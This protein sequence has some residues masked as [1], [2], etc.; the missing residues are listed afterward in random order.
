MS[1][2]RQNNT[3]R[4]YSKT[5]TDVWQLNVKTILVAST[6]RLSQT[7]DN[8]TS[9]QYLSPV[10]KDYHRRM[11]I[12]RQ[13]NTCRQY[14]KTFTDVCQ[15]NVNTIL[16]ASTQRLSHTYINWTSRQYLSPVLKDYQRHMSIKRQ[17]HTCR[18]Y[19]KAITDV[20]Q[21]N[22]KTIL[23]ATIKRKNHTCRQYSKTIT[24]VCQLNVKTIL[25]ASTQKLSHTYVNWTSKQYL[26]PVLKDYRRHM[27]IKR[28]NNTC[29]QYSKTI[30]DVWQ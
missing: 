11:S 6:Q 20:C 18:Q 14:S 12:K 28:Q 24:D 21:L 22:V 15:L 4:K 23:V 27:S 16:V 13:N 25:F 8:K 1:I 30:T 26:S 2:K 7:Y 10:L 19:S 17:N 9:K 5:I 3:C 29:R